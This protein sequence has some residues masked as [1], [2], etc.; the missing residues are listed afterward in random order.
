L[1]AFEILY[2]T[3]PNSEIT[4]IYHHTQE[5]IWIWKDIKSKI[6]WGVGRTLQ[7]KHTLPPC[8]LS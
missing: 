1:V 2:L 5:G 8:V 6:D 4:D 3:F 7:R